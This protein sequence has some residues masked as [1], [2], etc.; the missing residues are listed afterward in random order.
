MIDRE[1]KYFDQP[2]KVI[3]EH[4]DTSERLKLVKN[5]I[6]QLVIF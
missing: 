4:V 3:L 1:K 5:I 6:S 2:L